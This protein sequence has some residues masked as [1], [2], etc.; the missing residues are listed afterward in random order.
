MEV[1]EVNANL[2]KRMERNNPASLPNQ[3]IVIYNFKNEELYSSEGNAVIPADSSLLNKIRL[4]HE[5]KYRYRNYEVLGFL[6]T[7]RYDRFAVIAAATDVYG[8]DALNNLR[9]I[10][11]VTFCISAVLVFI[12]GW[13]YSGKVLGPITK[14]VKEV[15][16]ITEVNLNQRLGEGNGKDELSR[17]ARTFNHML[18][19]LQNAFSYQ[20]TFIANAS[21]EIKT[22][23]TIMSAEIEVTLLQEGSNNDY[24]T[25]LKSILNGLKGLNK[26]SNQLLLLAQTSAEQPEKNFAP[27]RIDDILWAVKEELTMANDRYRIDIVFPMSLNHE[28]LMVEGDEQLIKIAILNLMDNACKYDDRY[29]ASV[30]LSTTKDKVSIEFKNHG[31]GISQ[32]ESDKIFN[33]FYRGRNRRSEKGFGIGLPL[34]SRIIHLH[35]GTIHFESIPFVETSFKLVFPTIN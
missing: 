14:I 24:I 22:P 27:I 35:K 29:E 34:V 6:F 25:V 11:V 20:K 19:R 21:H 32:E 16:K 15:D 33:P 17:L 30:I 5:I 26:L 23:I 3:Y 4:Q 31:P 12:L 2:L 13:F 1:E 10:L 9:N 8:L 7:D 18:N 28:S